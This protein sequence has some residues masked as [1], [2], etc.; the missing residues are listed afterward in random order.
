MMPS[1][2]RPV[3]LDSLGSFSQDSEVMGSMPYVD[4]LKGACQPVSL[5][6]RGMHAF[7]DYVAFVISWEGGGGHMEGG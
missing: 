1:S 3:R 7:Y 2:A 6:L 5:I 4:N